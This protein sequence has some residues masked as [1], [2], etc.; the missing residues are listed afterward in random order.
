MLQWVISSKFCETLQTSYSVKHFWVTNSVSRVPSDPSHF[1]KFW[2]L[3]K[4]KKKGKE[5]KKERKKKVAV[6]SQEN[7]LSQ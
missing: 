7:I 2:K 1:E 6:R 3:Q 5:R 4:K